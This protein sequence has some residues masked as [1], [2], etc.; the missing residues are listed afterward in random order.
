MIVC[1]GNPVYD[2]IE[3]PSVRTDGR[4]L[5]GCSTH[6][7]IVLSQL[8]EK[9]GLVGCIGEDLK[10]DFLSQMERRNIEAHALSSKATGGFHLIYD[11][12]GNR[13]LFILGIADSIETIPS[14]FLL[15]DLILFGPILS[16]ISLRFIDEVKERTDARLFLDPQGFTRMVAGKSVEKFTPPNMK[17]IVSRFHIVKPNE[18]EAK[19]MT[20]F[21]GRE[22]PRAACEVLYSWG[23]DVA[24]VT[25]A[26]A[27]SVV[28][29]GHEFFL[30]PAYTTTAKDPT[31]AGDTYA[32]G[33]IHAYLQ[34][35]A[36]FWCGLFA[37]CVASFWVENVGPDIFISK[38]MVIRR[39]RDLHEQKD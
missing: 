23:T 2:I 29:D 30:I 20:G 1:V 8:E 32:A 4:I 10:R 38:T 5:S 34:K 35:K 28:Y 27:G 11:E 15:A 17:D 26:E 19:I 14:H 21:D 37:S 3:T 12:K 7:A 13:E 31:G 25:R 24:I 9:V 16:E 36:L 39:M 22:H 6:A 33:F 18:H